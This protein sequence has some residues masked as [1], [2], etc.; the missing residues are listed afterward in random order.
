MTTKDFK[1]LHWASVLI[2]LVLPGISAAQ[3]FQR[4]YAIGAGGHIRVGNI[5]G[6]IKVYGYNGDSIVVAGFKEGPD[7]DLVQ[8]EDTS[9]A[10]RLELRVR[11]PNTRNCNASVRFEISVPRAVDYNFDHVSSVSGDIEVRD[12]TGRIKA[13]SVSGNVNVRD[14]TGVVNANSVSGDVNAEIVKLQGAGELKFSSVSGSVNVTAPPDLDADIEM[15][16]VSGSLKTDF[17]IEIKEMRYGPGQ[18]A[19]GRLGTGS[20]SLRLTTVSGRVNF[21]RR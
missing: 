10:D 6:D 4:T 1:Y 15:S 9:S 8:I 2:M 20:Y 18:S 3:D 21:N 5:S 12:I 11:Y 17:P 7:R 16:S 14:V 13:G 19:R